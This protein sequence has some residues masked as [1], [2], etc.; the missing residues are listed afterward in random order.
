MTT[1][2]FKLIAILAMLIDHA[3]AYLSMSGSSLVDYETINIMRAIGRMALPIFA[4]FIVVGFQNTRDVKKYIL[5]LHLF[6]LISQIPFS[7]SF[8]FENYY[9]SSGNTSVSYMFPNLIMI[10]ALIIFYYLI[11]L[12]KKFD[13][14]LI[15]VSL[16]WLITPLVLQVNGYFLLS[17]YNLNIF[18]ELGISVIIMVY[19]EK[20]L[21]KNQKNNQDRFLYIFAAIISFMYISSLANYGNAAILLALALYLFKDY[22]LLQSLIIGVWGFWMYGSNLL[23]FVLV[24]VVALALLA[25]NGKK[26]KS[27]KYI[28]YVFYPL[29]LTIIAILNIL[30][31]K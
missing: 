22:K 20:F 19:L 23:N 9:M 29:H 24:V 16:A 2:I 7:L 8:Q 28:F 15:W 4:Y 10:S 1:F 11:V 27:L 13:K 6:A 12:E 21:D 5:R 3:G 30:Q 17:G 18:Y 25:Y 26:G 14:S 31:I